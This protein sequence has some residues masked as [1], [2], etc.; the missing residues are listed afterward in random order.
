M[1]N[2]RPISKEH[3]EEIWLTILET[4]ERGTLTMSLKGTADEL[5]N[6]RRFLDG[7]TTQTSKSSAD[8][9]AQYSS[10]KRGTDPERQ[11]SQPLQGFRNASSN[12]S[13]HQKPTQFYESFVERQLA[14][15][16]H[17]EALLLKPLLP[18]MRQPDS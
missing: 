11:S 8:S 12:L 3:A 2:E 1:T 5:V 7:V 13:Q 9:Q 4:A 6:V 10:T 15:Q 18:Y 17:L 16:R 14:M